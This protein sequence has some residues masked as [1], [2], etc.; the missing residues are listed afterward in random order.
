MNNGFQQMWAEIKKLWNYAFGC[1]P[2]HLL[3][4][5][6][7]DIGVD[8]C[9]SIGAIQI[10]IE[11]YFFVVQHVPS[12]LLFAHAQH[13]PSFHLFAHA[14]VFKENTVFKNISIVCGI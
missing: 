11:L 3:T 10:L 1:F 6:K 4:T 7:T 9:L 13:V 14:S 5:I 8:G 2:K 12:F